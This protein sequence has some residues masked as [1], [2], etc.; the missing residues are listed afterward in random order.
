M[1][2]KGPVV[3]DPTPQFL[4]RP[5]GHRLAYHRL[6]GRGPTVVFFGGFRSDMTGTKAM[7]LD[8]WARRAGRAFLRFDYFAHGA[9]TGAFADGTVGRW[10][11]DGLAAL[12]ALTT[13][14]L[15]LVG[16]SMGGWLSLLAARARPERMA[17]WIGIAPA[18]DFTE[19]L[20]LQALSPADRA[21]L[22]REGVLRRPSRYADEPDILTWRLIE[23]GRDHLVLRTPL[24]LPCRC[25]I[26][27]GKADPDV[28]WTHS[29]TLAAHLEAPQV[30]VTLLA[31]G[32]HRLSSPADIDRLIAAIEDLSAG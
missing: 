19:D 4:D 1:L 2:V 12:D 25:K 31:D 14:P 7:A 13:G 15:I 23:E 16:S 6:E 3:N 5:G 11:D 20:M 26:L 32:D 27:H 29:M 18:P 30:D 21:T 17:G 8:A 28:P 10:A 22:Q 9:S 24:R